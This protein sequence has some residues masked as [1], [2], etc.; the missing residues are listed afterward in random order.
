MDLDAERQS[1]YKTADYRDVFGYSVVLLRDQMQ[2][3]LRV[4]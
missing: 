3:M 1:A 4:P 2:R